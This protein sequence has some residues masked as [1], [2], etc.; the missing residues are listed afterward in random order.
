MFCLM[1]F[2]GFREAG[3]NTAW[4]SSL[5][6]ALQMVFGILGMIPVMAFS[7]WREYRADAGGVF[8]RK[9]K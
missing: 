2:H 7:R 1:P 3:E 5:Q 6:L 4:A 9:T 8:N